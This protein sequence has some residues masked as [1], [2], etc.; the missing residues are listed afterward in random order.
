ME[1]LQKHEG[2]NMSISDKGGYLDEST[3]SILQEALEEELF[4]ILKE[5]IDLGEKQ[6]AEI[7]TLLGDPEGVRFIVHTLKGSS[8]NIGAIYLSD[9]CDSFESD[10]IQNAV[11][12]IEGRINEINTVFKATCIL[13]DE[14][15]KE[16]E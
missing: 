8:G 14:F 11:T 1:M 10:L 6:I 3:L 13:I 16:N 7:Y 15:I 12:N 4:H 5:Y 2:V 9:I